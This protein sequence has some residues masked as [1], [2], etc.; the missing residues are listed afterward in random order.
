[1]C[2]YVCTC[3]VCVFGYGSRAGWSRWVPVSSLVWFLATS[4]GTPY[5]TKIACECHTATTATIATTA[6]TPTTKT[7][8]TTTRATATLPPTI[9]T[10][11][12]T[13]T[14]IITIIASLVSG[15]AAWSA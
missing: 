7:P 10:T 9:Y 2:M 1:M 6:V 5:L 14:I 8:T 12:I 4:T 13:N 11:T 15:L 3:H